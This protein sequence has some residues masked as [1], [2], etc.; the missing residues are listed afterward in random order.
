MSGMGDIQPVASLS[1]T[2]QPPFWA[3][4]TA[5]T[6]VTLFSVPDYQIARIDYIGLTIEFDWVDVNV[7]AEV[8][9]GDSDADT[10]GRIIAISANQQVSDSSLT[11]Q[12][13][14]YTATEQPFY[15]PKGP[16]LQYFYLGSSS[17][18]PLGGISHVCC[19]IAY[20][21]ALGPP[22]TI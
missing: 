22:G 14:W 2:P 7:T 6:D 9:Y 3:R 15:V 21:L 8:L 16:S 20:S 17:S 10:L 19:F 12:Q 1:F 4:A 18:D 5:G 11:F 13:R